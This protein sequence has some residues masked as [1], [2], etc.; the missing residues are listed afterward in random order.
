MA[1]IVLIISAP[2]SIHGMG[3]TI[4]MAVFRFMLGLAVGADYPCARISRRDIRARVVVR[5]I[6][7]RSPQFVKFTLWQVC[8]RCTQ[9]DVARVGGVGWVG[10]VAARCC[11]WTGGGM[12]ACINWLHSKCFFSAGSGA[13]RRVFPP[14][15]GGRLYAQAWRASDSATLAADPRSLAAPRPFAACRPY[16]LCHAL[17][18]FRL[19]SAQQARP[20]DNLLC[21]HERSHRMADEK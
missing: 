13:F 6:R 8:R 15:R 11:A 17:V 10:W 21:T 7:V 12:H 5:D 2:D 9:Y 19:A 16:S 20:S 18:H 4:W 3:V 1:A 14:P